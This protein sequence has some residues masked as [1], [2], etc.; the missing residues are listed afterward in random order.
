MR[1][2]FHIVISLFSFYIFY[3][4]FYRFICYISFIYIFFPQ[5]RVLSLFFSSCRDFSNKMKIRLRFHI[6]SNYYSL[7]LFYYISSFPISYFSFFLSSLVR[8]FR[9]KWEWH[10]IFEFLSSLFYI[11]HFIVFFFFC[12]SDAFHLFL[13]LSSFNFTDFL[14]FSLW[15]QYMHLPP[16]TQILKQNFILYSSCISDTFFLFYFFLYTFVFRF[17]F[18]VQ[19]PPSHSHISVF[20]YL[21]INPFYRT[22]S[23]RFIT[24]QPHLARREVY[25][26]VSLYQAFVYY[27]H[28]SPK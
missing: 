19:P 21:H 3:F 11:L 10:D 24:R 13:S 27:F 8:I 9:I 7:I 17:I 25:F 16:I 18:F 2:G 20:L 22:P 12:S 26:F 23:T 28:Y 15:R 5:A 1:C 4:S 6:F 14:L